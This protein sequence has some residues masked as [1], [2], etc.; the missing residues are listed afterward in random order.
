MSDAFG[1]SGL[2]RVYIARYGAE[3]DQVTAFIS[4]RKDP[5]EAAD[6]AAAYGRFLLDNGG[7]EA[8]EISDAPD[9]KMYK[10]FDVYE[11]VLHRGKFLAGA[12]EADNIESAK[13]VAL[14][15]YRKLGVIP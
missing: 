2:D 4:K 15:I 9:S 6:L 7:V 10:V 8:G 11:V 12:H 1:F 13:D 5:E 3:N 14:R